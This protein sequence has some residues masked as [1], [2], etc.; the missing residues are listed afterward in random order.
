M[1]SLALAHK[2]GQLKQCGSVEMGA[3]RPRWAKTIDFGIR[4]CS[5]QNTLEHNN[6][7]RKD[8]IPKKQE[9]CVGCVLFHFATKACLCCVSKPGIRGPSLTYGCRK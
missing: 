9:Y 2:G 4:L 1:R 3:V 5:A 7:A 6:R 8:Y